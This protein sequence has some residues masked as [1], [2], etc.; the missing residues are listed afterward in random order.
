MWRRSTIIEIWEI[1][2]SDATKAK[3]EL[4][5]NGVIGRV[6][7]PSYANKGWKEEFIEP[8]VLI[9]NLAFRKKIGYI[10]YSMNCSCFWKLEL[11][12]S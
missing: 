12:K 9:F 2:D 1:S 7:V 8:L 6:S 10:E 3:D 5:P 4:K 11:K